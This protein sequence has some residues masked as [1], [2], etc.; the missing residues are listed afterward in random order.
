[1]YAKKKKKGPQSEDGRCWN[2]VFTYQ[3]VLY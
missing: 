2:A 1:M 3:S